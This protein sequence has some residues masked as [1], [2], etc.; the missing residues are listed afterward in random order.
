MRTAMETVCLVHFL[1][2]RTFY[3]DFYPYNGSFLSSLGGI[4]YKVEEEHL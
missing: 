2:H 4:V 1:K 3:H